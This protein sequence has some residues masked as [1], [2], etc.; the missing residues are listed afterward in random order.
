ME[1]QVQR[2]FT[3]KWLTEKPEKQKYTHRDDFLRKV[4]YFINNHPSASP[5]KN[6]FMSDKT[7]L[8]SYQTEKIIE[9]TKEGAISTTRIR[10]IWFVTDLEN[11]FN[12][13]SL[14]FL[15]NLPACKFED[16][17]KEHYPKNLNEI[18]AN[19]VFS[20]NEELSESEREFEEAVKD[21]N[22]NIYKNE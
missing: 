3:K 8:I 22:R 15:F 4:I 17:E 14:V 10:N 12:I 19:S 18:I 9:P 7:Y 1:L 11:V 5:V 6:L 21:L 20:S 2:L 16:I 13:T